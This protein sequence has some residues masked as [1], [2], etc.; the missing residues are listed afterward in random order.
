MVVATVCSNCGYSFVV[1]SL[2]VV[3]PMMFGFFVFCPLCFFSSFVII[4]LS[5]RVQIALSK[6]SLS[7]MS[8]FVFVCR[9]LA[10]SWAGLRSVIVVFP[11][12]HHYCHANQE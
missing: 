11:G 1:Y 3:A 8:V 2:F 9:F 4:S 6:C 7:L 5:K 10:V 12:H